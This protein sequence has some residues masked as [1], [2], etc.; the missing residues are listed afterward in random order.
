[1]PFVYLYGTKA[2]LAT[3]ALQAKGLLYGACKRMMCLRTAQEY[4]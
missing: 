3:V 1:M 2:G 4:G